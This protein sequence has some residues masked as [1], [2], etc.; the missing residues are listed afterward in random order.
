[1]LLLILLFLPYIPSGCAADDASSD[2]ST[3]GMNPIRVAMYVADGDELWVQNIFQYQWNV[4]DHSYSFTPTIIYYEDVLGTGAHPLTRDHF[5][6]LV[7]G[8]SARSYLLHGMS[9]AW[10]Q[11]I[12]D[13]VR[14]GGGYIGM[15][16]GSMLASCGVADSTSVFHDLI[17]HNCLSISNVHIH[18]DFFGELQ[19]VLKNGFSFEQW[20]QPDNKTAGYVDVNCSV[21]DPVHPIFACY[22]QPFCHLTYAGG[23]AMI[24][25][26]TTDPLISDLTPLLMYNEELMDT[27]P[28]HFYRPTSTGWMIWKN[29]ST[30]L[31]DSFAG[32]CNNYGDG[33]VVLFSPHP[34]LILTVNGTIHEYLDRGLTLYVPRFLSPPQYVFSY[35]GDMATYTNQWMMRR[36]AAWAVGVADEDLPPVDDLKITVVRPWTFTKG[37]YINNQGLFENMSN[38]FVTTPKIREKD[39]ISVVIGDM[40]AVA[41]TQHCSMDM[42]VD[43]YIDDQFI[44][45]L[46][47]AF[48]DPQLQAIAYQ[49]MITEP[50]LG[51]HEITF[52]VEGKQ[53]NKAWD[54]VTALFLNI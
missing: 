53:G 33:K 3:N 54:S 5:D 22:D 13:F 6:V 15:C 31:L 1:M 41:Y 18:D 20:T 38:R 36:S 44:E 42:N 40:M 11:N 51:L 50:L 4:H 16:A 29:V 35:I 23:P 25:S 21:S 30:D 14:T 19:Y 45:T 12:R 10:K 2:G 26:A 32:V 27:K 46:K 37:L 43:F 9:D 48:T 52:S 39:H 47:P 34:E 49:S 17:N 7:I 8:A 24:A 28:L